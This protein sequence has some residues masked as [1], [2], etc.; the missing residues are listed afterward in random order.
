MNSATPPA[1]STTAPPRPRPRPPHRRIEPARVGA[2][3]PAARMVQRHAP[4]RSR[5]RAAN[6]ASSG[7]SVSDWTSE[8]S[9]AAAS[10]IDSA[11]KNC[12]TTPDSMPSGTNTTTVVSVDPTTGATSSRIAAGTAAS[13]VSPASRC[14]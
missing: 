12:P 11:R 1:A 10:V 8:I 13:G 14:R 2:L 6:R 3:Q 4:A 7:I 9:T 5:R